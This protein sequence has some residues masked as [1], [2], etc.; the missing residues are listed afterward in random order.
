[1]YITRIDPKAAVNDP[2]LAPYFTGPALQQVVTPSEISA[3]LDV[4][5]VFFDKG[6]V[7]QWHRHSFPQIIYVLAGVGLVGDDEGEREVRPGEIITFPA[8]TWHWHGA[9]ADTEMHMISMMRPGPIEV[10]K[11]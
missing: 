10:R 8:Q 2:A 4:R 5:A 9:A 11:S 1:M 7:S 6:A 3:E